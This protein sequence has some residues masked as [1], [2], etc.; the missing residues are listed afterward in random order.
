MSWSGFMRTVYVLV[1]FPVLAVSPETTTEVVT[2]PRE[3]TTETTVVD[4]K[5]FTETILS[6]E[7]VTPPIVTVTDTI[8]ARDIVTE[9]VT[10]SSPTP[11][12]SHSLDSKRNMCDAKHG[13]G[14]AAGYFFS[15]WMNLF[16]CDKFSVNTQ[17][18]KSMSCSTI[19]QG[20]V[21]FSLGAVNNILSSCQEFKALNLSPIQI[22]AFVGFGTASFFK[23]YGCVQMYQ[24]PEDIL[25]CNE[26]S[27]HSLTVFSSIGSTII[28][29]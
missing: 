2:L 8:V 9:T 4:T 27:D 5:T 18:Y 25:K 29:G 15:S 6:R 10:V 28:T 16:Y 1:A 20:G 17:Y 7:R 24:R 21:G 12:V 26:L 23:L 14:W 13:I 11:T 19:S 3:T 22:S